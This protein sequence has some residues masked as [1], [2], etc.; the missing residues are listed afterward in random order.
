MD[1]FY[2]FDVAH[3]NTALAVSGAQC[4]VFDAAPKDVLLRAIKQLGITV[5]DS[6]FLSHADKDHVGGVVNLLAS[7]EVQVNKLYMNPDST[8]KGPQYQRLRLS[9][10]DAIKMK[11][12]KCQNLTTESSDFQLGDIDLKILAP[13]YADYLSGA[14][15]VTMNGKS[16][17]SNSASAVIQLHHQGHPI[18]LL[19]ADMSEYALQQ[20][21]NEGVDVRTDI[22]VFPHHG[23]ICADDNPAFAK[24]LAKAVNSKI[25]LFSIGRNKF[26]NPRPEI[27]SAVRE[28]TPGTHIMCTQ[29]SCNCIK[30]IPSNKSDWENHLH[31][32]PSAG[33][34]EGISCSGSISIELNGY[35]TA[36][37]GIGMHSTF[38]QLNVPDGICKN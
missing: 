25:T 12:L 6:I 1:K 26:D 15:G 4:M 21:I 23:G 11:N 37:P 32:L 27:V 31:D 10:H 8:K 24:A 28:A 35:K 38:V 17:D 2:I 30:Q 22:L 34:G 14:G 7:K 29:L 9:I 13:A 19:A 16:I 20:I 18:A 33:R 36:Y 3:G 5:I